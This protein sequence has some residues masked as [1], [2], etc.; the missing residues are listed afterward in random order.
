[1]EA[2]L[3]PDRIGVDEAAVLTLEVRSTG[4]TG[5]SAEPHFTLENFE[6]VAGP[7]RSESF[8]WVNGAASRSI[9]YSWQLQPKAV[10]PARVRGLTIEAKGQLIP[11]PD[12]QVEVQKEPTG[13]TPP[14]RSNAPFGGLPDPF[15]DFFGRPRAVPQAARPKVFLRAVAAPERAFVG[16]QVT[17]TVYLYTQG[18]VSSVNPKALPS[19]RGFW[20]RELELPQRLRADM[21]EEA[22]ERYGRVALL[23][24]ALF[25]LTPGAV[26][27]EPI[28]IDLGVRVPEV[29]AF[30]PLLSTIEEVHR[31]TNAVALTIDPLPA[32]PPGFAGAIGRIDVQASLDRDQVLQGD[33]ATLTVTMSGDGNLQG[34]Q[35]PAIQL[36]PGLKHFAP[37]KESTDHATATTVGG[38]RSWSYVLIPEHGGEFRI[39]AIVV[40]YFD[41]EAKTY[42]NAST[43]PLDLRATGLAAAPA[44]AA[45]PTP[46]PPRRCCA[47]PRWPPSAPR[48]TSTRCT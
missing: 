28:D 6:I 22:G 10:G 5:I 43:G 40:P 35:A 39:P 25:A 44:A 36:P 12:Q 17:Y 31:R 11:L 24:R 9:T 47:R 42:K 19:F 8:R 45:A 21:V 48:T 7:S 1:V 13:S 18:D 27:I 2:H 20:V 41:P 46:A 32:P 26:T 23:Q 37:Q 38:R 29:S 34:L 14:A 30:G 33:A 15:E 16:Q 4:M 3:E